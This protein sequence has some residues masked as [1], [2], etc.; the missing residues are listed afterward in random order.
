MAKDIIF[1]LD[2]SGSMRGEKIKQLRS[3]FEE[4]INQLH[5]K[6]SFNIIMFDNF[7]QRYETK[8]IDASEK[9]KAEAVDYIND[10]KASGSTN[11]NDALLCAL[12]MFDI[13]ETKMPIIV[14]LTDGLPTASVTNTETIR[15]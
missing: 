15:E 7:F 9:N 3:A 2:K 12:D 4:V 14:M 5:A 8:M 1:V 6:D 10:I 13:S 11:I